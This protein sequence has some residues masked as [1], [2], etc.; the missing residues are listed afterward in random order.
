MFVALS[1]A[2]FVVVLL[3]AVLVLRAVVRRIRWAERGGQRAWWSFVL[4][5]TVAGLAVGG[6]FGVR[7][8]WYALRSTP[9]F[10]SLAEQPDD[11]LVGTIA[12]ISTRNDS[13]CVDVVSASGRNLKEVACFAAQPERV[14]WLDDQR[15]RV[16]SF[17]PLERPQE[18]WGR[19][20]DVRTG[21]SQE[22]AMVEVPSRPTEVEQTGPGGATVAARTS[23]G[24]LEVTL[25]VDRSDRTLLS[26]GA[27]SS[28]TWSSF[29]W[30]PT[31]EWFVAKD[32]L[33]RLLLVTTADPSVTRVLATDAYAAAVLDEDLL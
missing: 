16:L 13:R 22:L 28:Y 17:G 4:V 1:I 15:L 21:V 10:A 29:A 2:V 19:I 30:S 5:L 27:P 26:V 20:V 14:E 9:D 31:G 18:R 24:R 25:T 33:D 3:L 11:S 32:D 7:E 8:E 23:G 6:F 12:F